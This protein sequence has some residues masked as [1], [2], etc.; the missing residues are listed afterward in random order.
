MGS[1][2]WAHFEKKADN[3]AEC[4]HCKKQLSYKN[5]TSRLNRH[6]QESCRKRGRQQGSHHG[7]S[8]FS[9]SSSDD[10]GEQT[11]AA[12]AAEDQLIRMIALHGFPSSMVEDVEFTRFVR[13]LCPDFKMPS[14]DDVRKRCDELFDREMSSLKDAIGRTP[15]LASLSLGKATT[16]WGKVA[17]LAAHFIDEEWNFH[18]RVIRVFKALELEDGN[19]YGLSK[20]LD[21]KDYIID[22]PVTDWDPEDY[23]RML[24]IISHWGLLSKLS[25]VLIENFGTTDFGDELHDDNDLPHLSATQHELL[26]ATNLW[27]DLP[28]IASNLHPFS[29]YG[30]DCLDAFEDE[31]LKKKRREI[32][33]H[34]QLDHPWTYDEWWY[35]HYYAL[36]IIHKE[37]SSGPAKIRALAGKVIFHETWI[38]EL[39]RT[40]LGRIYRAIK[41]ISASSLP[42]SNLVLIEMLEVRNTLV[43]GFNNCSGRMQNSSGELS[44]RFKEISVQNAMSTLDS[45]LLKSYLL[46]SIPLILDPRYKLVYVENLLKNFQSILKNAPSVDLVSKVGEKFRELFTE[47]KTQGIE[48]DYNNES[49][50]TEHA[51]HIHEMDVDPSIQGNGSTLQ[52]T[53]QGNTSSQ[54]HMREL[55]AYLQDETVPLD[56]ED[57]DVLKW[58]KDNCGRYPTVARI[59]RDFLAIP[60]SSRPSSQLMTEIRNHLRRY[61]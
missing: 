32:S 2:C 42:T 11:A 5:G 28:D 53:E 27:W 40:T 29:C 56:Q 60:T 30:Q 17:Y 19:V 54:E 26:C 13:M 57:F 31:N 20:I 61:S 39:L 18:C 43:L 1:E 55:E 59:A 44:D 25:G 24:G 4:R 23:E 21:I 15:G 9:R 52:L 51:N 38:T 47:Y 10:L 41:T 50:A 35:A 45:F 37:C 33:S 3:M 46:L 14:R 49:N 16:A 8:A 12:A 36:E 58:W 48:T 22:I 6:Y 7:A 34:L